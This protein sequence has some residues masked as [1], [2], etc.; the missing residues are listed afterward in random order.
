VFPTHGQQ[1]TELMKR[2]ESAL[3][4]AKQ[5]GRNRYCTVSEQP[6]S[7]IGPQDGA[8]QLH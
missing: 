6:S 7:V 5:Q 1:H 3:A 2:A 8:A 4:L